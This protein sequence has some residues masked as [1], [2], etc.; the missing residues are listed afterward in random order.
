MTDA[1]RLLEVVRVFLRLG[2]SSFGGPVAH[3]G[4]FREAFVQRRDWI[5]ETRFAELLTLVHALPGP[6]ST[7]LGF[8]IGLERAGVVGGLAAWM[9]FTL[10]SA[11]LMYAAAQG[12]RA[13][14]GDA[15]HGLLAGLRAAAI[16]VVA[17]ALWRMAATLAPDGR[18][19]LIALLG[20]LVA[21]LWTSGGGQLATLGV[22]A[23][24]GL[25]VCRPA[26]DHRPHRA[27]HIPARHAWLAL[28]LCAVV[29]AVPW[30]PWS[31][32]AR[33]GALTFGGGHV[34]LPLLESRMMV[35]DGV[36]ASAFLAGYGMAQAL[37]GPLFAF[38]A[39]AGALH[40][41]A[42]SPAIGSA[43]ATCAIFAPGLLLTLAAM[44]LLGT[45]R[46]RPRAMSA[47][48]GL[49]AAVVG[50]LLA[51]LLTPI[52]R[53]AVS[54]VPSACIAVATCAMLSTNRWPAPVLVMLAGL[55]GWLVA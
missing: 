39:F 26:A 35:H 20:A 28:T 19:R 5:P 16:G 46:S 54:S 24:A 4:Y 15:A 44:P 10:P 52:Q 29:I 49:N 36:D 42:A 25:L 33:S 7:Q 3:V 1:R 23:V 47:L 9:A 40:P 6:A 13:L 41:D 37:P 21:G 38:A 32:F 55:L 50:L 51:A 27:V 12:W 11:C 30:A 8:A 48:M 17:N 53:A 2:C 45:L 14:D 43:V 22:G 31:D 34:V 18:R